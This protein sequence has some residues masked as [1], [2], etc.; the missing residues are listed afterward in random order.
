MAMQLL[1]KYKDRVGRIV[2]ISKNV[3]SKKYQ[4]DAALYG[5]NGRA[6]SLVSFS[7]P[8]R[9]SCMDEVNRKYKRE[10]REH[11]AKI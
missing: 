5:R 7:F 9:K 10:L 3:K 1:K 6:I 11:L 4:I 8:N 2:T